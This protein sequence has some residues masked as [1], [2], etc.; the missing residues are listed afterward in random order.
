M[1]LERS[2]S[3]M[4][5]KTAEEFRLEYL[6]WSMPRGGRDVSVNTFGRMVSASR[7]FRRSTFRGVTTVSLVDGWKN[8]LDESE[9][10]IREHDRLFLGR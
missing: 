4:S 1:E 7:L 3:P 9:T 6:K 5:R 2:F 10:R 8:I